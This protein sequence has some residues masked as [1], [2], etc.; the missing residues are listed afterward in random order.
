VARADGPI[1][2][3]PDGYVVHR[4]GDTYLVF[5]RALAADLTHLR[6]ADPAVRERLFARAPVRGRGAAP[7][8]AVRP[9]LDMVLRRYR[10]GGLLGRAT[11]SLYLGPGRALAELRVAARAEALDA[12]VPHVVCLV[13]WPVL[14]PLWSALIGTREER[15]ARHLLEL[16]RELESDSA[17]AELA[18]ETGRAVKRLHDAGV[19][20]RDLQLRNV[21]AVQPAPGA[22]RRIV[23]IDLDR[24]VYHARGSVPARLRAANL[25]RLFRSA[26]K[27]GLWDRRVGEREVAA[28]LEGYTGEDRTLRDALRGWLPRER[29]KLGLHRWRYRFLPAEP[30]A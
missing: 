6:L 11:G 17:R 27:N 4:I 29:F 7:S 14:G 28:F 3:V 30:A 25:G 16:A 9:A 12:P 15:G 18:R 19:E 21:L 26:L 2:A 24:A 5:D 8:V 20:H 1:G 13:L 23:V 22:P 10:H